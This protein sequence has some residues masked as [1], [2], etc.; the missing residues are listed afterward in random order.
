MWVV[1][2]NGTWDVQGNVRIL[3]EPSQIWRDVNQPPPPPPPPPQPTEADYLI[4]LD[5]RLSL[6]E[7][8]L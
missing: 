4:D 7:L 8:G 5:F 3:I 2:E 1:D 6:L